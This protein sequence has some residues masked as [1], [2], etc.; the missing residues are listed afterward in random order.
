MPMKLLVYI[1]GVI[2]CA[3]GSSFYPSSSMFRKNWAGVRLG[4]ESFGWAGA[5]LVF[6]GYKGRN[7]QMT[8]SRKVK[9]NEM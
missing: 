3:L 6:F 1:V 4:L 9:R 5:L 8:K 7:V 2:I